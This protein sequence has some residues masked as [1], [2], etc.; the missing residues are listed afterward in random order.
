MRPCW[1]YCLVLAAIS[2]SADP[3]C[4]SCHQ[5]VANDYSRSPKALSIGKPKPET[6]QQRYWFDPA[7]GRRVGTQ[8]QNG[9]LF[10]WIESRGKMAL[11]E[12][13]V[14]V[15]SGRHAKQ[16]LVSLND[17]LFHSPIA[18]YDTRLVWDTAPGFH[19]DAELDFYRPATP[20]CLQCHSGSTNIVP[21]TQNRYS[22]PP[23]TIGCDQCH[24]DPAR[25][26]ESPVAANIVNPKKL[27]IAQRDSVCE[28]CHLFGEARVPLPGKS[29]G[30]FRPGQLLEET[31]AVF[32]PRKQADDTMLITNRHAEQ[33]AESRCYTQSK[34]AMWCGT[35]HNSHRAI[36]EKERFPWYRAK[37]MSCH[38]G[39]PIETH[40]SRQG[41]DC[42]QCHMRRTR[43]WDGGHTAQTDHWIRTTKSEERFLD[44]GELLRPWRAGDPAS[45]KRNLAL[46]YMQS[47][48]RSGSLKRM[49][50]GVAALNEV[51]R[52]A[53][54]DGELATMAGLLF[55]QQ[56]SVNNA[57]ALLQIASDEQPEN[58][59]R[60]YNL[61]AAL[62][63][64]GKKEEAIAQAREALRIEPLLERPYI[65]L[66]ELD[67]TRAQYWKDEYRKLTPKRFVP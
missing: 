32:V 47:V 52:L 65:L 14:S 1:A 53:K 25:H 64:A 5:Q 9:K 2:A 3:R 4:A 16:Y 10:H 37:C 55:L 18:W 23:T 54:P 28:S 11:Y 57:V 62:A 22:A 63:A 43:G 20:E 12:P 67:P 41:D 39:E 58:S 61:A 8:T 6:Q 21:G 27:P 30:D 48:Q 45:A 33:L 51:L 17:A 44:R 26:L 35:C 49:R 29:L 42:V 40:R 34:G 50:E 15:G 7:S 13:S 59:V 66:A 24:G 56:K 38:Q 36:S 60:R 46:A 19:V 31:L